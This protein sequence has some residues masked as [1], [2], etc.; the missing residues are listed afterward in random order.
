M[1]IRFLLA[2]ACAAVLSTCVFGSTVAQQLHDGVVVGSGNITPTLSDAN[3]NVSIGASDIAK[4][5]LVVQGKNG[6]T[7]NL[8]DL[9]LYTG[10]GVG[11]TTPATATFSVRSEA[12]VER[13]R[14]GPSAAAFFATGLSGTDVTLRVADGNGAGLNGGS[15]IFQ[16]GSK[17][18]AGAD[19]LMVLRGALKLSD[20]AGT[21][22]GSIVT[23]SGQ[24]LDIPA[25]STDALTIERPTMRMEFAAAP[26]R[27]ANSN[28]TPASN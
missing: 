10:V 17:I 21:G 16:A 26:L 7:A 24:A 6:Q 13:L 20:V 23:V 8:L 9:Q 12:G 18:G 11:F 19:G 5:V 2:L 15:L 3:A 22:A 27:P 1:K 4:K 28:L 25:N 14:V